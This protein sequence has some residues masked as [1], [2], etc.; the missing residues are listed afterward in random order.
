MKTS[1]KQ[2]LWSQLGAAIDSLEQA[3]KICPQKVWG[4]KTGFQEFWYMTYHTL[5]Y[6]DYYFSDTDKEFKP[7]KPYT[8]S[9]LDPAGVL[10]DRVYT[11]KEMLKYL[12]F[13]R[14]KARKKLKLLT[15]QK[16]L[17]HCGFEK[18]D[19]T[20]A[21]QIIYSTRHIQHHVAQL[22]LLRRQKLNLPSNWVS[23]TKLKL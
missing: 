2:V 11:K 4:N 22:N 6:L 9:E 15:N 13:G 5:F 18:K 14:R 20:A 12:E 3:I 16:L 23:R 10:P 7:P 17:S 19:Y 21:E 1:L 8:L